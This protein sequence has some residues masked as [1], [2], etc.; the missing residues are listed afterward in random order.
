MCVAKKMTHIEAQ[1]AGSRL[2]EAAKSSAAKLEEE[3]ERNAAAELKMAS[4][5]RKLTSAEAQQ[6]GQRLY[7][8]AQATAAKL[9]EERQRVIE[10]ELNMARSK[11]VAHS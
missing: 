6:A 4:S 10:A 2:H 11:K 9:E 3:R 5:S 7:D 1:Y 8:K